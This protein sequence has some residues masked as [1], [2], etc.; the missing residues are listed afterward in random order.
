M[1]ERHLTWNWVNAPGLEHARVRRRRSGIDVE[2]TAVAELEGKTTRVVYRLLYDRSW[3]FQQ[4]AVTI[5]RGG[6]TTAFEIVRSAKGGWAVD[7]RSRADLAAATDLDIQ[8]TPFT[9]TPAIHRLAPAAG[10]SKVSDV[11]YVDVIA[12]KVTRVG[13]EYTRLD[14]GPGESPARY[15]Y[16]NLETGWT[17]ELTV[18]AEG[19]VLDY[20]PWRR[21]R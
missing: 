20:G 12:G 16:R 18:D 2:G 19:F 14:P 17:G 1:T 6:R 13:Q 15:R 4:A 3:R 21:V 9:N 10:E 8:V 7:G 11:A 5:E